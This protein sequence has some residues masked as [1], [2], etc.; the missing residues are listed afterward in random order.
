MIRH[1]SQSHSLLTLAAVALASFVF[2]CSS[3][4]SHGPTIG[5]PTGPVITEGGGSGPTGAG[6]AAGNPAAAGNP[7]VGVGVGG[8]GIGGAFDAGGGPTGLGGSGFFGAAGT[9]P[10]SM[11]GG[12]SAG[13]AQFG[14]AGTPSSF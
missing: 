12:L 11:A 6:G 5:A 14:G 13:S 8:A 9:D 10:F 4:D 3:D 2:G 7:G 1:R